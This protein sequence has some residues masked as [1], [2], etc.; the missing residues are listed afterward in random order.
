MVPMPSP[1]PSSGSISRNSSTASRTIR[2]ASRSRGSRAAAAIR[3]AQRRE[4]LR[5]DGPQHQRKRRFAHR[6]AHAA[7][8]RK[9]VQRL[10]EPLGRLDI[11]HVS[12]VGKSARAVRSAIRPA[13]SAVSIGIGSSSPCTHHRRHAEPG[14]PGP[15]V[16]VAEALPDFLLGAT[17]NAEGCQLGRLGASRG[18]SRRPRA[19]TSG[20][21]T[22][23]DSSLADLHPAAVAAPPGSR[24]RH[25]VRPAAARI[26]SAPGATL[27]PADT[28]PSRSTRSGC[29][30]A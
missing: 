27:A 30:S 17:G 22:P 20:A 8:G 4:A 10:G 12:A 28:R 29:S 11:R 24:A 2:K 7:P 9:R 23:R 15:E 18:S 3:L 13:S 5:G 6:S 25:F 26:R 21:G 19:R 14:Q 1:N 16:E